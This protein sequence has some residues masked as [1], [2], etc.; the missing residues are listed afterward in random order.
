[1]IIT[2]FDSLWVEYNPKEIEKHVSNKNIITNI[3]RTQS[4]DSIMCGCFCIRFTTFIFKVKSVTDFTNL[5]SPDS[6]KKNDEIIL[7]WFLKENV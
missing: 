7:N 6:F 5:L 4:Y 1:M 2:Y 3:F